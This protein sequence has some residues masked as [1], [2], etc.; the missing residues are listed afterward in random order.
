VTREQ[1]NTLNTINDLLY[2]IEGELQATHAGKKPSPK[3]VLNNL[4]LGIR[5]ARIELTSITKESP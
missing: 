3:H 5:Q 4:L 1:A 2:M